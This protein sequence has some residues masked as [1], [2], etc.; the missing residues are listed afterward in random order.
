M[1][2]DN[3]TWLEDLRS[4]DVRQAEALDD[5][6]ARI[7]RTLPL[8]LNRWLPADDPRLLALTDEV[9]Q[10]TL[11]RVLARLDSFQGRSRF[12]TWVNAIAVHLALS[13]LRR[14]RWRDISL[15]TLL[16]DAGQGDLGNGAR[17]ADPERT[18]VQR[19]LLRRLEV[20]LQEELTERQW[21][22]MRALLKGMPM[23]EVAQRMGMKRN[24]LYKLIFDARLR[25]KRRMAREGLSPAEM[26]A[27]FEAE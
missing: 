1:P 9:A 14:R 4:G 19:D 23:E 26:M 5:L 25:L 16:D 6:R 8:A 18:A 27:A 13:E 22:A 7:V 3:A 12:T 11:V 20:I 2:R 10:E 15:E 21:T 24:A 17:L